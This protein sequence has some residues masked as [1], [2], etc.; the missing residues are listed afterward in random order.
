MNNNIIIKNCNIRKFR[1]GITIQDGDNYTIYNNTIADTVITYDNADGIAIINT[2]SFNISSNTIF[3]LSSTAEGGAQG[4]YIVEKTDGTCANSIIANNFIYNM[5]GDANNI[6]KAI[7]FGDS[8]INSLRDIVIENNLIENISCTDT[9]PPS[10][11]E[12]HVGG[13][14]IQLITG[15]NITVNN[16]EIIK[17]TIKLIINIFLNS[18]LLS[19]FFENIGRTTLVVAPVITIIIVSHWNAASNIPIELKPSDSTIIT[20][21]Y[22]KVILLIIIDPNNG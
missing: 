18:F 10:L 11:C 16:N 17:F 9:T 5:S 21:A 20:R 12:Q 15:K 13:I 4:I 14:G 22:Q 7:E 2:T 3:N 1:V 19:I 6:P 8:S